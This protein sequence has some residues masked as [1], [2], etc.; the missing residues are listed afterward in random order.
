MNGWK[1]GDRVLF[2]D[3]MLR[4]GVFLKGAVPHIHDGKIGTI[5]GIETPWRSE[6][7]YFIQFNEREG[8]YVSSGSMH[9]PPSCSEEVLL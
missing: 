7:T 4:D 8:V 5:T 6:P 9:E 3:G 1:I 2:L